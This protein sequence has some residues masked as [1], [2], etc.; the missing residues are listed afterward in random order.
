MSTSPIHNPVA[1]EELLWVR[2]D[3]S[4]VK[5][6]ALVGAPYQ[7]GEYTWACAAELRGFESGYPDMQGDSSMQAL[8]LAIGLLRMRL[9]SLLERNE[10]LYYLED[11]TQ[12]L[13]AYDLDNVFG[14]APPLRR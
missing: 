3:G 2:Q 4:K 12:K 1:K 9:G 13:H 14:Y 8:T 10:A 11:K 7:L 5:I 6:T